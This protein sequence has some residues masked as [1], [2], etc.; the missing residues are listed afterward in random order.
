MCDLVD[1]CVLRC[2]DTVICINGLSA[3]HLFAAAAASYI[4]IEPRLSAPTPTEVPM[5][6]SIRDR[7]FLCCLFAIP[8]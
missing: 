4:L 5:E 3:M 6:T 7:F 8:R 1:G 2:F